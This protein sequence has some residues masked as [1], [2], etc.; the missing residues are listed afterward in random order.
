MASATT[1]HLH[2]ALTSMIKIAIVMIVLAGVW[3]VMDSVT[4]TKLNT[5]RET[6][7]Q[8][9]PEVATA[10]QRIREL[11]CLTRNIY[12]EAA[13][14]PFE[15]K[16]AVAQVTLNRVKSGQF[17][18]GVCGVVFQKNVIYEKVICQFSWVCET[19]HRVKPIQSKQYEESREVA[20][21]VLLE[22]FRLPSIE[23]A[24]YYHA[25]YV[26]PGWRKQR[27]NQIGRHIFY[28]G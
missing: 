1:R 8:A 16:V 4:N 2:G 24:I 6:L 27:I 7:T 26:N 28:K 5:L 25:T 19:T 18:Q 11:D 17:G 12:W 9:T 23:E 15:G 3:T 20:K 13:N 22:Q 10:A 14:E 21:K